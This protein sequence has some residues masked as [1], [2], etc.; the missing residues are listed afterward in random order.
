M[1]IK[2]VQRP[3]SS[4][5]DGI[6][7]DRF[8]LGDQYEMGNQLGSLFLAEG[9]AEPMPI[10]EPASPL[11]FSDND[12]FTTKVLDSHNP[13]NLVRELYPP[14]WHERLPAPGFGRR[15]RTRPRRPNASNKT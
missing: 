2:M 13:A 4:S 11:L 1:R 7:L 12:L 3:T 6:Q 10:D 5:I 14:Y 15:R 8:E 9:W